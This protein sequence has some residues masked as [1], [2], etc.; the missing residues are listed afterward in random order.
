[1][2]SPW[3][4]AS[5]TCGT[6]NARACADISDGLM[7]DAG[8]IA[9]AS[10]VSLNISADLIPLSDQASVLLE[11]R[12]DLREQLL[13]GGDDYELLVCIKPGRDEAFQEA[14]ARAGIRVTRIGEVGSGRQAILLDENNSAIPLAKSGFQHF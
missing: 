10:E 5:G 8:H 4:T 12:P 2:L 7:A 1:M 3:R 6:K 14:A 9:A 11:R 13:T